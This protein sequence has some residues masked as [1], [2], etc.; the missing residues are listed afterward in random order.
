MEALSREWSDRLGELEEAVYGDAMTAVRS[1]D[2]PEEVRQ[3]YA[4]S[5]VG[6]LADAQEALA[7]AAG[8]DGRVRALADAW[9]RLEALN[10]EVAA[11]GRDA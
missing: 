2:A 10:R 6:L 5:A 8:E 4:K 11:F 3:G 9:V 1:L 7:A